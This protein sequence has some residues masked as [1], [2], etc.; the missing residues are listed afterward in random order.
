MVEPK[1]TRFLNRV[2]KF[3]SCR[4]ALSRRA[5]S[6]GG[7]AWLNRLRPPDLCRRS[8][9]DRLR[10]L[11]T[12][13]R[14]CSLAR[15]W[16]APRTA[17]DQAPPPEH[18][19]RGRCLSNAP[20]SSSLRVRT[21]RHFGSMFGISKRFRRIGVVNCNARRAV[22]GSTWDARAPTASRTRIASS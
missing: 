20:Q 5:A 14:G 7:F 18:F 13:V 8:R 19:A 11:N 3:D 9:A 2:R 16:R 6:S 1:S 17:L 15:N 4:G 21:Q 10:R 22:F 12:G